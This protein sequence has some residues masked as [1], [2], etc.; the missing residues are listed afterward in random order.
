M[1][2]LPLFLA[3]AA[4]ADTP[5]AEGAAGPPAPEAP[6]APRADAA[7]PTDEAALLAILREA[8]AAA[9]GP[10]LVAA[11]GPDA[12]RWA[13]DVLD[14]SPDIAVR[15]VRVGILGDPEAEVARVLSDL[16][17]RCGVRVAVADTGGSGWHV[18]RHGT[19][20]DAPPKSDDEA[21]PTTAPE[22]EHAPRTAPVTVEERLAREAEWRGLA[23]ERVSAPK[24]SA[25][26]W[27]VRSG[28]GATLDADEFAA[29]VG[30]AGVARRITREGER[31]EAMG[32][33]LGVAGGALL[34]GALGVLAGRAA[35]EP[36]WSNF[37]VSPTD[38]GSV[39]EYETAAIDASTRY[40]A[41]IERWDIQKSDRTW[42][43]AFLASSGVVVL[44]AAPFAP[45]G[46]QARRQE[47]AWFWSVEDADARI[48]AYNNSVRGRLGLPPLEA[49]PPA[50]PPAPVAPPEAPELPE[51]EPEA[52][53][54]AD[55]KPEGEE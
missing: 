24:G 39:A 54:E 46:A 43:A 8:G 10:V 51:A 34:L 55:D 11:A 52:E 21:A 7:A 47:P 26:R 9:G 50:P 28:A 32:W 45:K 13:L 16:G 18:T 38:Y 44:G 42:T 12:E 48:A 41:A 31:A 35:G 2:L 6:E 22:P 53:P 33:G 5:T 29:T 20:D 17:L 30:D 25:V 49:P 1:L 23:L 3:F 14:E 4:H 40:S 15:V 19:C 36:D 27:T 37:E